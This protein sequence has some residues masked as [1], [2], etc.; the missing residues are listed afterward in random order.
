MAV[1]TIGIAIGLSGCAST[2]PAGTAAPT[3]ATTVINSGG[4]PATRTCPAGHLRPKLVTS[5]SGSTMSQPFVTIALRNRSADACRL[6]GYPALAAFGH[7]ALGHGKS[8][9]S[10]RLG[11]HLRRGS[12]Y[13]RTDPGPR[14]L[15]VPPYGTVSFT[16]GTAT[17]YQGGAHLLII[18]RFDITLTGET[19][20][21]P[22]RVQM[23]ASG[24]R[25]KP[26]PV[27]VTALQLVR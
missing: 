21:I 20:A 7:G 16:V 27:G 6:V 14:R 19:A 11:I 2:T 4:T 18:T 10:R 1:L 13:E 8:D 9:P 17:A 23:Y 5:A 26:I 24:P 25:D 12:I 22:V 3:G 15:V